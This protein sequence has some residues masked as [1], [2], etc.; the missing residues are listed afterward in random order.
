MVYYAVAK[1]NKIGVFNTWLECQ[2]SI[3]GYKQARF[4]KFDT[5]EEAVEFISAH[6]QDLSIHNSL[7]RNVD[8]YV[9]TDGSCQNNGN[10]NAKAGIG[11]FFGE[12]DQRNVSRQIE[13]KKTNNT[14]ELKAIIETFNII[15]SDI[16]ENKCIVI[17]TDSDYAIKC[18]T[19]YGKSCADENWTKEIPNKELVKTLYEL[20]TR[21]ENVSLLH[22]K[23]HTN[24]EDTHSIG[25]AHADRLANMAIGLNQKEISTKQENNKI[26]LNV[27]YKD[28]D[29]IKAFDG[30]WDRSKK[31][32]Y[33]LKKNPRKEQVLKLYDIFELL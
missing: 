2:L 30:K 13:G 14:A 28:K 10:E 24:N 25:N 33:I 3:R 31:H 15:Q 29:I 11:I 32:W 27:P 5:H 22:I 7:E 4:K 21:S 20:Y 6:N 17:G 12:E 19:T 16:E 26:Y 23:A 1:G 8:L 18:A 9:Y